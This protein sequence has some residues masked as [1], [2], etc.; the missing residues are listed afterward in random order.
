[1]SIEARLN[2]L[3]ERVEVNTERIKEIEISVFESDGTVGEILIW[4][5]TKEGFVHKKVKMKE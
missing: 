1:M 3:E 4:D 5:I 2:K